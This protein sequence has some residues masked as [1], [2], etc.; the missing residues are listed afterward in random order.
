MVL[1]E[2]NL[3]W[4]RHDLD[5]RAG[6]QH[7]PAYLKLNPNGVVPTL[8]HDDRTL[9]E[10]SVIMIYLDEVFPS[11][12]LQPADTWNRAQ[13]RLWMKRVDE[14][15]HPANITLTYSIIHRPTMLKCSPQERNAYYAGIPNP[16]TRERQRQAIELGLDSPDSLYAVR[17]FD[18]AFERM[19]DALLKQS[20]LA[21]AEFSLADAAIISYVDRAEMLGLTSMWQGRRPRV[22]DWLARLRGRKSYE[23]AITS[24]RPAQKQAGLNDPSTAEKLS[25]LLAHL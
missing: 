17:A 5:L 10:S 6:E 22:T 25:E 18:A 4:T 16:V 7:Q 1:S 14:I 21:G 2:K 12:S 11:R 8:V 24:Y 15:L 23:Q 20:W 3:E 13:T 19:E 9:V